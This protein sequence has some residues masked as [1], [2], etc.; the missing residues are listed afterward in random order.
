MA[1]TLRQAAAI[2]LRLKSYAIIFVVAL[3]ALGCADTAAQ[4]AAQQRQADLAAVSLNDLREQTDQHRTDCAKAKSPN[5]PACFLYVCDLWVSDHCQT[6][7]GQFPS[8]DLACEAKIENLVRLFSE[9]KSGNQSSCVEIQYS[10]AVAN[11]QKQAQQDALQ[12]SL[13]QAQWAQA[14]AQEQAA[15]AQA[16]AAVAV[17][18]QTP[19][20]QRPLKTN[21][22]PN[23]VGGFDCTQQ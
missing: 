14:Q 4:Q 11:Q 19:Q 10:S 17:Q 5:D 8:I 16:R 6:H 1:M 21:C 3:A 7:Y 13:V 18:N 12:Q 20:Y 2:T 15:Q 22:R 9:C 23:A